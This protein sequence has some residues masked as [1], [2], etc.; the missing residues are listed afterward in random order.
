MGTSFNSLFGFKVLSLRLSSI[1]TRNRLVDLLV[2]AETWPG[3]S[4][5]EFCKLDS[6][7]GSSEANGFH[8]RVPLVD[9]D[10]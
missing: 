1:F 5:S 6:L 8:V 4:S 2:D 3:A 10:F 9:G 7:L